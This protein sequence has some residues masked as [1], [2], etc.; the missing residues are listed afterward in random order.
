MNDVVLITGIGGP[1]GSSSASYV[2]KK[3]FRI[4]GADMRNVD[5]PVDVFRR[6]PAVNDAVFSAQLL[7]LI[8]IER[9]SLFIPTVSEELPVVSRLKNAI[10][11]QGCSVFISLPRAVDMAHDKLKTVRFFEKT[12]VT[13][14]RTL[15][16]FAPR[17]LVL[18]KLGTPCLSKPCIGRGGRGVVVY[19]SDRELL[20]ENRHGLIFQEFV[21]GQEYD[22]NL[23]AE[24]DGSVTSSAVLRKTKLKQGIVGN[25]ASVVKDDQPDIEAIGR[26]VVA[27]LGLSGPLD[28]DI[29]RR[30]DGKPV[31]LEINA[32]VGGNVLASPEILDALL[33]AWMKE[34]HSR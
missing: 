16:E 25:A 28:M 14:P 24:P 34:L 5:T 9:P 11:E 17:D 31:L 22:L 6:L 2:R 29:R 21:S 32:R 18:R 4:I 12:D 33:Q 20:A 23:F 7:A 26:R 13:V 27:H 19:Q 30:A 8:Q 10:C 3:G 1:A 15:D